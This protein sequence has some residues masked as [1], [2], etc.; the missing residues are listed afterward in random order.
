[1]HGMSEKVSRRSRAVRGNNLLGPLQKGAIG[2]A[3]FAL[4]RL[5]AAHG[6]AILMSAFGWC[7]FVED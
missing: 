6:R 4:S 3:H 2:R 7:G 1:V 5:N